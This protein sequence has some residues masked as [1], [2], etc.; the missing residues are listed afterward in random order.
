MQRPSIVT[1]RPLAV[2]VVALCWACGGAQTQSPTSDGTDE[3]AT[4][5]VIESGTASCQ[6]SVGVDIV[7]RA[8]EGLEFTGGFPTRLRVTGPV[9]EEFV[10]RSRDATLTSD[11]QIRFVVSVPSPVGGAGE[12][13]FEANY[14]VCT[15]SACFPGV[16]VAT[17]LAP[18][19]APASD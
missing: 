12:Y 2:F 10:L 3:P 7:L 18:S 11:D 9:S 13:T 6:G 4:I 5:E 14:S 8:S 17:W 15:E 16:L 19:C 1:L